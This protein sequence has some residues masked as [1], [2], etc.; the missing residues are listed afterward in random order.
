M[1]VRIRE[2]HK[3]LCWSQVFFNIKFVR[4]LRF[5]DKLSAET[6]SCKECGQEIGTKFSTTTG[7]IKHL[8]SK[9]EELFREF[10]EAKEAAAAAALAER[11]K[12]AGE[13]GKEGG[14]EEDG[15]EKSWVWRER[16]SIIY[17]FFTQVRR[18]VSFFA[19]P[20]KWKHFAYRRN[21]P[22][23][24]RS[25]LCRCAAT[26]AGSSWSEVTEAQ[27]QDGMGLHNVRSEFL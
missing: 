9:H 18:R 24:F 21:I 2:K 22:S 27:L 20:V 19:Q 14:E 13:E 11:E 6:A 23:L 17:S 15:E 12:E 1:E 4:L 16:K 10:E 25:T 5:F 26:A 3:N 7:L 8:R